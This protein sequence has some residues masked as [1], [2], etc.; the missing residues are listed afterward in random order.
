MNGAA[1]ARVLGFLDAV[2]VVVGAIVGVGIFLSP[3]NIAARVPTTEGILGV[4]AAGAVVAALG[5]LTYGELA[6]ALPVNGGQYVFLKE[7]LGPLPAFLFGW[8]YFAVVSPGAIAVVALTAAD[9]LAVAAGVSAG[10]ALLPLAIVATLA[11]AN[12]IGVRWGAGVQKG[13]VALKLLALVALI[14]L[15]FAFRGERPPDPPSAGT[16]LLD[17]GGALVFALFAYGGW[18]CATFLGGEVRDPERN[19]PRAILLGVAICAA[20]YLLANAAYLR[21]LSPAQIAA[22]RTPAADAARVALGTA[23]ERTV[24][25]AIAVSAAGIVNSMLLTNSR[26]TYA[27]AVAGGLPG[28]F[29]RIGRRTGT[30]IAAI[31]VEAA[32]AAG[33]LLAVGRNAT[34]RL[35][36]G[37]TFPDWLSFGGVGVAAVLLRLRRPEL[38]RPYRVPLFVPI[39]FTLAAVAASLSAFRNNPVDTGIVLGILAVGGAGFEIARARGR[40]ARFQ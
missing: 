29:G 25:A 37:V 15:G 19:L 7:A 2:A 39:L 30:P 34:E 33:Y 5:A 16:G 6:C 18:Q 8:A 28:F 38:R 11:T 14:G 23:V 10:G 21:L 3:G 13:A 24:A 35:L 1:P 17:F 4:W 40:Q 32:L 26:I 9:H 36:N 31:L 12:V 27:M 20:V 22:S